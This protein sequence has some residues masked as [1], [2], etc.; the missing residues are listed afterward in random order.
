MTHT[1]THVNIRFA[2]DAGNRQHLLER[3][4]LAVEGS[5]PSGLVSSRT[6]LSSHFHELV[7]PATGLHCHAKKLECQQ[8]CVCACCRTCCWVIGQ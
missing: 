7:V 3:R 6:V 5:H 8:V 1:F 4:S 2:F